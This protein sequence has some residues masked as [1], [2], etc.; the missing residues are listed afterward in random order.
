[1]GVEDEASLPMTAITIDDHQKG[2]EVVVGMETGGMTDAMVDIH[3][4]VEDQVKQLL[5]TQR[6]QR[7]R[8]TTAMYP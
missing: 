5:K 8:T 4:V 2:V 6:L 3:K 7:I 1:M